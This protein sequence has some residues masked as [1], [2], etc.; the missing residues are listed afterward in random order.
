MDSWVWNP[1]VWN[2]GL[3]F[4]DLDSWPE[5]TARSDYTY[6]LEPSVAI[7]RHLGVT[8]TGLT[9]SATVYPQKM[10][11]FAR[12]SHFLTHWMGDGIE[13]EQIAAEWRP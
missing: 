3:A 5:P 4:L 1:W 11:G 8:I 2:P 6:D 13:I 7:L 10:R 12:G 9:C